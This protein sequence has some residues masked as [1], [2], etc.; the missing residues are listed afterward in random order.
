MALSHMTHKDNSVH[1]GE[2]KIRDLVF[3]MEL[4]G[5]AAPVAGREGVLHARTAGRGP[6][7]ETVTF[8][9]EVVLSGE[10]F[11]ESGRITYGTRGS[12]QFETV[13]VGHLGPSP[14]PDTQWG[15][16]AWHVTAGDGEFQG[17]RG[18]LTSNFTVGAN[19]EVVDNQYIRLILA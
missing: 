18:Y 5:N 15:V 4:R 14:L 3:A 16:I 13:G 10:T 17:A 2:G 19:G 6:T 1:R 12:T 11:T 8:E 9:S 7:G